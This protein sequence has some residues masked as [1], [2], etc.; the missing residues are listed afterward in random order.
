MMRD[1]KAALIWITDILKKHRIP[2]QIAGGLAAS[3]YGGKR[4]LDDIDIDIPED[5]FDV[6]KTD[7]VDFITFGP[8][9]FKNEK[10]DVLLMTLNYKGQ[11]ID[12]SGAYHTKIFNENTKSWYQLTEDLSQAVLKEVFG[13]QLPV[14]PCNKLLAYKKM[15][16]REVDL[17]DIREL[18]IKSHD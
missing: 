17:I 18:Q 16:A 5:K 4:P 13:L 14:M 8:T 7:V 12:L 10:W 6:I 2:F 15:L 3:V 9:N 11:E 1:T